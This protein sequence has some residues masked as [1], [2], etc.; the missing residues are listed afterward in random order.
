MVDGLDGRRA[1][2]GQAAPD[3]DHQPGDRGIGLVA[4]PPADDVDQAADLGASRVAH[5]TPDD[6]GQGHDRVADGAVGEGPLAAGREPVTIGPGREPAG[7][8]LRGRRA[9]R[10]AATVVGRL[11][12]RP[13][14]VQR[15][16]MEE[17]SHGSSSGLSECSIP[18]GN[19]RPRAA[20]VRAGR[21]TAARGAAR[22]V[23]RRTTP[24]SASCT[25]LRPDGTS[26]PSRARLSQ[27]AEGGCAARSTGGF[28]TTQGR[29]SF[30]RRAQ[31][32]CVV[33]D[34]RGRV[35]PGPS[36]VHR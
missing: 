33:S 36:R 6:P 9:R 31:N 25:G 5:G 15:Q 11:G 26:R 29:T 3:P 12:W 21:W 7:V 34:H 22:S 13:G 20:P 17:S 18:R 4:R 24:G 16:A 32:G 2:E 23:G 19:G 8:P 10:R 27:A 28:S 1:H 14:R 30:E 35:P